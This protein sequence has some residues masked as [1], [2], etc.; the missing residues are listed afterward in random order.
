M[1][2]NIE[3]GAGM[4]HKKKF[5]INTIFYTMIG[6]AVICF[7]KYV[8]PALVPFVIAFLVSALVQIP[9]KKFNTGS[10]RKKKACAISLCICIYSVF[11]FLMAVFGIKLLE[12]TEKIVVSLPEIY[13]ESIV[14]LLDLV[15][16]RLETAV[17]S[18]D[19]SAAQKIKE[20]F[21]EI[22]QN[23]GKYASD[24]SV[25][26]VKWVSGG[27]KG[28]PGFIVKLVI[29]VIST[30]FMVADFDKMI[31]FA[32]KMIPQDKK[33][34]TEKSA[35]YI[36]NIVFVYIKSYSLLFFLT[37]LEL[38][39]GLL[40]L[41]IPY[42]VGIALLIAVFDIL[43]VLG[44]GGILLPWA[45]ILFVMGNKPLA[46]GI[47][48]LYI[49]ITVIRNIVEPKIVGKQIGLHPLV[50]LAAMFIGLKIFGIMGM[51]VLP[52]SLAVIIN[53]EKNGIVH[54]FHKEWGN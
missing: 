15:S 34:I 31:G 52:V 47:L 19:Q 13:N 44:T 35:D 40:V 43:P 18:M 6:A 54:I 11:F 20:I 27:V 24:I 1:Q 42:A 9:I 49:I 33:G 10:D 48:I 3:E 30:F 50:T 26:M 17:V 21:L 8:L 39:I 5:I 46:A 36:K 32:R 7:C 45:V 28:I 12:G 41:R 16:V 53:L 38:S 4:E 2:S 14:P 29:T 25:N 51:I 22:T 23:L 37:F